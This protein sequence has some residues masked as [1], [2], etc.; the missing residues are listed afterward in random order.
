MGTWEH[1]RAEV[2]RH[3]QLG[4]QAIYL[5]AFREPEKRREAQATFG[6]ALLD[7]LRL[8]RGWPLVQPM[9]GQLEAQLVS[10]GERHPLDSVSEHWLAYLVMCALWR[11]VSGGAPLPA[12]LSVCKSCTLVF[13]PAHKKVTPGRGPAYCP[14]CG[15]HREREEAKRALVPRLAKGASATIRGPVGTEQ[16]RQR[17]ELLG[18]QPNW[19]SSMVVSRCLECGAYFAGGRP[20]R[21]CSAAH[22]AR[23]RRRQP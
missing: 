19:G 6:S 14:R 23:W 1:A 21:W 7:G 4:G 17:A 12:G 2:H 9:L 3:R 20:K 18:M 5:D 15:E 22:E 8:R 16:A 11:D 13:E 10:E